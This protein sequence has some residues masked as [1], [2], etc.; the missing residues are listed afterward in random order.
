MIKLLTLV[1]NVN[2]FSGARQVNGERMNA[3]MMAVGID[4]ALGIRQISKGGSRK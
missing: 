4:G 2:K 1:A 3:D